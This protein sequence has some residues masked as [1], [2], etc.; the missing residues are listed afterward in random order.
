[1]SIHQFVFPEKVAVEYSSFEPKF[2][3][4]MTTDQEGFNTF[5]HVLIFYEEINEAEISSNDFDILTEILRKQHLS[6]KEPN[7]NQKSIPRDGSDNSIG[8]KNEMDGT[9]FNYHRMKMQKMIK[10]SNDKC[11]QLNCEEISNLQDFVEVG[12]ETKII[13]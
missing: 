11:H 3:S 1:M 4:F 8:L 7:R 6:K 9:L 2:Y 12:K 10:K 5:I 13:N